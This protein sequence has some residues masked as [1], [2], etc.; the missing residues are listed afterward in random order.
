MKNLPIQG[1]FLVVLF[2]S[3]AV[4]FVCKDKEKKIVHKTPNITVV[5]I[6]DQLAY[7]YVQKVKPFLKYGLGRLLENGTSFHDATHPHAMPTTPT[8]HA[9][10]STGALPSVHG[11]V[12][13]GYNNDK[14]QY[15]LVTDSPVETSAV[16]GKTGTYDFGIGPDQLKTDTICDQFRLSGRRGKPCHSFAISYKPRSAVMLAGFAGKALWFD[17]KE[18][19]ITSSKAY[20]KNGLPDWVLKFNQQNCLFNKK[21]YLWKTVYPISSKAYA[22]AIDNYQYTAVGKSQ[23]ARKIVVDRNNKEPFKELSLFP[24]VDKFLLKAAR[25]CIGHHCN[26]LA[27]KKSKLLLFVSLSGFDLSSHILGP[28]APE[29]FDKIYHLDR[30]IGELINY[31]QLMGGSKKTLFVLTADHGAMPIPE[32]IKGRGITLAQRIDANEIVAKLDDLAVT[33]YKLN[34]LVKVFESPQFFFDKDE[35]AKLSL[36][37]QAQLVADARTLVLSTPGIKHC[38]TG[39]ELLAGQEY[40]AVNDYYKD[41]FVKQAFPG[42]VGDLVCQTYAYNQLSKYPTGTSHCS[43]YKYD[44]HVPLAFYQSTS[45]DKA[46]RVC[47]PVCITSLAPTL[48]RLIGCQAPSGCCS[49]VLSELVF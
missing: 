11:I 37:A 47:R 43:P 35:L 44:V 32:I 5:F 27:N 41:L 13:Y 42:R 18:G 38:W 12:G 19:T 4:E 29:Q 34:K 10:I 8:G 16:F 26:V 46:K 17:E 36:K 15:T 20:F 21:S 39:A 6:V 3:L 28:D 40:G 23:I 49:P 2:S 1:F 31:A 22:S 7:H 45:I 25:A 33:K 48:A 30:A 9:A 24:D 14:N